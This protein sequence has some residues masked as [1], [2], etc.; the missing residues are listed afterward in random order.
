MRCPCKRATRQSRAWGAVSGGR[1]TILLEPEGMFR[2][3]PAV[4]QHR[5][6][7]TGWRRPHYLIAAL[8]DE[9]ITRRPS[10]ND[11]QELLIA[12]VPFGSY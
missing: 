10:H 12:A 4:E 8:G 2:G 3:A 11:Q 5:W 1:R 7:L 9:S 6:K